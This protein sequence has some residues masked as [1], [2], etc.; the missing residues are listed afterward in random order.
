MHAHEL[1]TRWMTLSGPPAPASTSLATRASAHL[2]RIGRAVG[3]WILAS[4]VVWPV[5]A[6]VIYIQGFRL[7][8][9]SFSTEQLII[10]GAI[11]GGIMGLG[12]WPTVRRRCSRAGA[13]VVATVV[14]W[15]AGMTATPRALQWVWDMMRELVWRGG[16]EPLG[17][18]PYW[19]LVFPL[20]LGLGLGLSLGGL[21]WLVLRHHG[22]KMLWWLP[23]T[24]IGWPVGELGRT[25][26]DLSSRASWIDPIAMTLI[27]LAIVC[28]A[29][30]VVTAFGITWLLGGDRR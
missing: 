20:G 8:N 23:L 29:Y 17:N 11:G 28:S 24:G 5:T 7:D 2:T 15:V 9:P 1:A 30:G 14:G 6:M 3:P 22:R 25:M 12:Q 26:L 18:P 13:W 10:A 16:R 27:N 4:T 21:Q 19:W